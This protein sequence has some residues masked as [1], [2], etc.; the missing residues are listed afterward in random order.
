M[1]ALTPAQARMLADARED[2]AGTFVTNTDEEDAT[3][4]ELVALGL[5]VGSTV[6]GFPDLFTVTP[7]GREAAPRPAP[8][9]P[10]EHPFAT[11]GRMLS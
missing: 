2:R 1:S 10:S 7:A 11:L 6:P 4:A 3:A 8:S 5:F 9:R